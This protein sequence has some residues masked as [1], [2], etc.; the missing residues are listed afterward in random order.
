MIFRYKKIHSSQLRTRELEEKHKNLKNAIL[1]ISAILR[2]KSSNIAY[3]ILLPKHV[4]CFVSVEKNKSCTP[5]AK[6]VEVGA[7]LNY[8]AI[9]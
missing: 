6:I 2:K 1:N 7:I 4:L 8:L 3:K 9:V 5:R